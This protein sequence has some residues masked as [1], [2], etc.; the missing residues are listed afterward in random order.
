LPKSERILLWSMAALSLVLRAIAFLNYRFDADEQQHLHVA[1]GWVDGRVQ[2]R[3]FF[4]NHAPLFHLV[5]APILASFGERSDILHWMR[6]PMLL[7]FAVVVCA[8]YLIGR[9]L[10]DER[11]GLWAAVLLSLFP[12][13]F[14]KSLEYRTDNL[15][16]AFWIAGLVLLLRQ[17]SP[18]LTGVV[19][20]CAM[21]TSL[22]TSLL[23]I[24]IAVAALLTRLFAKE[25][26]ARGWLR[27]A[28]GFAIVPAT[29]LILFAAAGAWDEMV[30]CTVTFNGNVALTRK[31]LWVQRAIFP[32]T[33][34]AL[35]WAAWHFRQTQKSLRYFCVLCMGVFTIVLAGFWVLIS[36][37][38]FLPLMPLMAVFAAAAIVRARQPLRAFAAVAAACMAGLWY[39]GDRFEKNTDW[40]TT[41][42]DQVLRLSHPGEP[43]IDQ[44]GETIF[45]RRPFYYVL[46]SI[47]RAQIA[48]GII[49]D[50]IPEDVVR[51]RTHV[52][53]ADGPIWPPRGR[54][55]LNENFIDVGRLRAS[56]QFIKQDGT[57][58]I[59][60]PGEYVILGAG[61]EARGTLDGTPY[62]GARELAAGPHRFERAVPGEDVCALWAPAFRRGHSP[63]NLRDREF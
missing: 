11:V 41:M 32:F 36:P 34:A 59:A 48:R 58:H 23:L 46:E 47:T 25:V 50:T 38:D 42:M 30:Y 22:K 61:G 33:A 49:K 62:S 21:A 51:T 60:I 57:F 43:V 52:A 13:F 15:W 55:F 24:T 10:Y 20:G 16:N 6:V 7:L 9:Q 56:G 53:Q 27:F 29:L 54:A 1:W 45:R 63:F 18:F 28:L 8:T 44:K 19:F 2:Y 17:R 39:Y 37:R 5:T 26:V 12:P 40:H 3:D 14:L 31:H 35:M 4:D